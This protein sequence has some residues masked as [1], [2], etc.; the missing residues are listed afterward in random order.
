MLN[1]RCA[2][3]LCQLNKTKDKIQQ[4]SE[5]QRASPVCICVC[6]C[7]CL[8]THTFVHSWVSVCAKSHYKELDMKNYFEDSMIIIQMKAV[9]LRI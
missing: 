2:K 4:I 7:V 8:C 3:W 1:K 5:E 6:V 9:R